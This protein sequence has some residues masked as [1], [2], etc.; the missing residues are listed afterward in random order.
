[1]QINYNSHSDIKPFVRS[2][3]KDIRFAIKGR[4]QIRVGETD[5]R[6]AVHAYFMLISIGLQTRAPTRVATVI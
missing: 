4:V 3:L 6:Q 2:L 5:A 1:M